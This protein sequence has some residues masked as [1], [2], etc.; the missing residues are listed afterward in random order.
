MET[1]LNLITLW[2]LL[3][4]F[5]FLNNVKQVNVNEINISIDGFFKMTV[6]IFLKGLFF[7]STIAAVLFLLYNN[8]EVP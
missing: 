4:H 7:G 5:S 8:T 3:Y 1:T 2:N 6:K